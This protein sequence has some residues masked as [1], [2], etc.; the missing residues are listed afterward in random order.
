I[1]ATAAGQIRFQ[2]PVVYQYA[3]GSQPKKTRVSA[4]YVL[5]QDQV[6][7]EVASYDRSRTLVIDPIV[8][9]TYLGGAGDDIG[10][11]IALDFSGDAYV[12][13]STASLSFPTT[14]GA[15]QVGYGGGATDVFV[16]KFNP[17]GSG[18]VYS[19]FLGGAG[20]D[21][22]LGIAVDTSKDALVT[23]KTSGGF[24]V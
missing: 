12:T 9:S 23:G 24:P 7:F 10:S 15:F 4:R 18:L 11:S 6:S 16:T 14:P 17:A 5:R 1:L 22:G 8:Y 19:T 2:K 21:A 3:D 13:G 20:N